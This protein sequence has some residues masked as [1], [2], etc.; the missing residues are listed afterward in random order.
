MFRTVGERPSVKDRTTRR[1]YQTVVIGNVQMPSAVVKDRSASKARSRGA[2]D[3]KLDIPLLMTIITLLILGLIIL[4][5]ASYDHSFKYFKGDPYHIFTRQLLW[6]TI[7]LAAASIALWIDYHWLKRLVVPALVITIVLLVVVLLTGS[8][9]NNAVRNLLGGSGQPSELAKLVL[10]V[11][12]AVWL[13]AKR[14]QIHDVTFGL[15][16]LGVIVSVLATLIFFQPDLSAMLTIFILG[17]AMFFMG[18]GSLKQMGILMTI[19]S[20]VGALLIAIMPTGRNRIMLYLQGLWDPSTGSWQVQRG[21][22]AFINGGWFGVGVG[23]GTVKLISL[24]TPAT[25]SILAVAGEELGTLGVLVILALYIILL[26]RGLSIARRATDPMGSLLA[27]GLTTW[28]TLEAFVNMAVVLNL[29]PSAGNVLPLISS[30]GSNLIFTL[31]GLGL[32][33]NVSRSTEKKKEEGS[34]LDAVVNLRGW[35]GRRRISGAG[36]SSSA[37]TTR[38]RNTI[39]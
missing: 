36:R 14:D 30:G 28:I 34:I 29:L 37:A 10:V 20:V 23:K 18:G 4:Y 35:N 22:E 38:S 2:L 26:W 8:E 3:F 39:R 9:T 21:I 6:L 27:A 32:I 25:D 19:V 17:G 1:R 15:L 13:N 5:S 12:L 33:L 24:P 16:P 11:Y 31:A 7:G